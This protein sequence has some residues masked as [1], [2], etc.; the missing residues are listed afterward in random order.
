VKL[1]PSAEALKGVVS[2]GQLMAVGSFG[3]CRFQRR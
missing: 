2:D 3:L 1:Y